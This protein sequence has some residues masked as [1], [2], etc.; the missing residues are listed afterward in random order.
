MKNESLH[1]DPEWLRQ[2]YEVEGLSTYDI[3][4]IVGRDPKGI[5]V[6]LVRFGIATRPRGLNLKGADNFMSQPG[7]VNPFRGHK[8]TAATKKT[9]SRKASISKPWLRGKA[10][11]MSGRTGATNPNF[12]DGSSPDR[13]RLYASGDGKDFLRAIYAR[14]KYTC[15]RCGASKK[16][17][18][19]LHAHHLKRWAGN[20][21]LRFDASNVVT[22]CR[23]C[24]RWVHS[25]KN[26]SS[27][28]LA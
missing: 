17:P 28:Y 5:Y 22:L 7:A 8:H 20:P 10:N 12:K 6:Q 11:G 18:R 21:T 14:D 25:T 27:E 15:Q 19:D 4:K 13:Q 26:V 23:T 2:K 9:L 1:F 24:H 3:G 16:G